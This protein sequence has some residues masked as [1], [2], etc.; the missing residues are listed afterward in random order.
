MAKWVANEF[1]GHQWN[2]VTL[3]EKYLG[4]LYWNQRIMRWEMYLQI[5]NLKNSFRVPVDQPEVAQRMA[6]EWV[7]TTL[8]EETKWMNETNEY[9]RNL[10]SGPKQEPGQTTPS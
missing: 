1:V 3:S 10:L 8:T 6:A 5:L 2:L 7:L 4:Q 9:L